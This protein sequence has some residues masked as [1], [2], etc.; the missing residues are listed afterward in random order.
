[1]GNDGSKRSIRI[2][3]ACALIAVL[4]GVIAIWAANDASWP[5]ASTL[6]KVAFSDQ[7]APLALAIDPEF[8]LGGGQ[9]HYDG[10]YYYAIALDPFALGQTHELI[11]MPG[12]RYG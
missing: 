8:D 2:A 11:D 9:E 7:L 5:D 4:A 6:V 12:Y 3:I 10:L 1:M